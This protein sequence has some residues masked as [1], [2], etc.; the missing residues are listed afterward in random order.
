MIVAGMSKR[1][2]I[3]AWGYPKRRDIAG[4]ERYENERWLYST[5]GRIKLVYFESGVVQGWNLGEE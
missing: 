4:Y 1:D 3:R 5:G 2:V